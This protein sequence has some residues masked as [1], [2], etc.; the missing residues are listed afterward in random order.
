MQALS[1]QFLNIS[2]VKLRL[3]Q[4]IKLHQFCFC[5]FYTS[6]TLHANILVL[7]RRVAFIT[8]WALFITLISKT[9]HTL[10][11]QQRSCCLL[12]WIWLTIAHF[13]V[14]HLQ[15]T[16]ASFV[17][18][19]GFDERGYVVAGGHTQQWCLWTANVRDSMHAFELWFIICLLLCI[20][21]DTIFWNWEKL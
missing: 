9:L 6:S 1:I 3:F 4:T 8:C 13:V 16:Y 14:E 7:S 19:F 2:Y 15:N 10:N 5:T 21:C 20:K 11:W 18:G 17:T 12:Y